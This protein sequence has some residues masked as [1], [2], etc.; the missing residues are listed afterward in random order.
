MAQ[1]L[2]VQGDR[3]PVL[4]LLVG[5]VTML[6]LLFMLRVLT[7]M[8]L[9]LL[10]IL[11]LPVGALVLVLMLSMLMTVG[12]RVMGVGLHVRPAML[13]MLSTGV[14]CCGSAMDVT[15]VVAVMVVA[16]RLRVA[17]LPVGIIVAG[18]W[19]VGIAAGLVWPV[20]MAARLTR[21]QA[22]SGLLLLTGFRAW[23]WFTGWLGKVG[24]CMG[25]KL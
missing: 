25:G 1:Q 17:A 19:P 2:I 3:L 7:R 11:V 24:R 16:G 6:L 12:A 14:A 21:W 15:G 22:V 8:G 20:G 13:G 5:I 18:I 10:R 23:G 9:R 4:D